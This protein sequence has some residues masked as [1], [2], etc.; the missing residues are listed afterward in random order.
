MAL[1]AELS[2]A[3]DAV[4]G[5]AKRALAVHEQTLDH[6]AAATSMLEGIKQRLAMD[7]VALEAS[8]R[9]AHSNMQQ[10]CA[11]LEETVG[12][13]NQLQ[14]TLRELR[15]QLEQVQQSSAGVQDQLSRA[16]SDKED[17]LRAIDALRREIASSNG[18]ALAVAQ[19]VGADGAELQSLQKENDRLYQEKMAHNQQAVGLTNEIQVLNALCASLTQDR[20][21]SPPLTHSS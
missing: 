17:L 11:R 7:K 1:Q 12:E 16:K 20:C 18:E 8:V 6:S 15:Q 2:S 9:N 19:Q 21:T 4:K 5:A 10:S 3:V 14:S 13:I